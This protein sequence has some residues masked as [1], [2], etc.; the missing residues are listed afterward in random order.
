MRI[1]KLANQDFRINRPYGI[2]LN[3]KKKTIILFNRELNMLGETGTGDLDTLPV[4]TYEHIEDIPH[5]LA[6]RISQ[7]GDRIDL[8]FYDD[9]TCPFSE[10]S[11][12]V[13]LLLAYNKKMV[14][15]S[16]LLDR[17]L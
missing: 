3:L 2:R 6:R 9:T 15:L 4:E 5:S 13:K 11:I 8:Y 12:N 14:T 17:K 1:R 10:N 7:N 16:G